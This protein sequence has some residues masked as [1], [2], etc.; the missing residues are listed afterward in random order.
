MKLAR[1]LVITAVAATALLTG[2]STA[3]A[4]TSSAAAANGAPVTGSSLAP[5]IKW[6]PWDPYSTLHACNAEG[7]H[8]IF[9]EDIQTF[10]C[11]EQTR[12]DYFVWELYVVLGHPPGS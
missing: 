3:L 10:K 4:A 5:Q 1:K 7:D 11:V 9:G 8:L 2:T 6:L 12:G